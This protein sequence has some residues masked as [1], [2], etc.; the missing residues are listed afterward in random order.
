MCFFQS[1]F[2]LE[3]DLVLMVATMMT[4]ATRPASTELAQRHFLRFL[5]PETPDTIPPDSVISMLG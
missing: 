4:S 5:R 2:F 3:L 1:I